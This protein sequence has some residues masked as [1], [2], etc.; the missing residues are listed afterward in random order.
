MQPSR[1]SAEEALSLLD[2][3]APSVP[4]VLRI[5]GLALLLRGDIAE[6]TEALHQG[7]A[8]SRGAS[9]FDLYCCL[10]AL[11][12]SPLL[13]ASERAAARAEVTELEQRLSIVPAVVLP[14]D[15]AGGLVIP[16]QSAG[17]PEAARTS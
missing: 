14:Y 1:A 5:R 6:G 12:R 9:P 2:G 16:R 4:V 7:V 15:A 8:L 13:S 10:Q 17:R 3:T 11:Q